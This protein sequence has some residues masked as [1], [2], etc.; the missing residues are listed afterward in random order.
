[1]AGWSIPIQQPK[2]GWKLR[3]LAGR[4]LGMEY[5]LPL[6]R[7]VIGSRPPANIVIADASIAY[8]VMEY[9]DG[10]TLS[11]V[12]QEVKKANGGHASD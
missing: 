3:V 9:L 1:M 11:Q 8:L 4:S 12:L 7:Y 6:S 10:C 2:G 5:D